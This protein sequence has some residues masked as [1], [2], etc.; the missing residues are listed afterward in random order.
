MSSLL[1][2]LSLLVQVGLSIHHLGKKAQRSSGLSIAQWYLL[3]QLQS[4]PGICAQELCK[5]VGVHPSTLTQSLKRLQRKGLVYIGEDP[6]DSRK[7]IIALTRDGKEKMDGSTAQ[8]QN[9]VDNLATLK[10]AIAR[11]H[12]HL[13]R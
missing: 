12:E 1:Q 4:Q 2:P 13:C 3:K 7:K 11:I 10:S 9:I 5:A 6:R 8:M